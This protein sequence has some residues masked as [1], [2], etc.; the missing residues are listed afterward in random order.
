M[1]NGEAP[2]ST[3]NPGAFSIAKRHEVLSLT[4]VVSQMGVKSGHKW[5]FLPAPIVFISLQY[6][7]IGDSVSLE[8]TEGQTDCRLLFSFSMQKEKKKEPQKL[9]ASVGIA[10]ALIF[11]LWPKHISGQLRSTVRPA[12]RWGLLF[13]TEY[14]KERY[15]VK[16]SF[17]NSV[18][19]CGIAAEDHWF[20]SDLFKMSRLSFTVQTCRVHVELHALISVQATNWTFYVCIK[21]TTLK[22]VFNNRNRVF[23]LPMGWRLK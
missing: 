1:A 8:N 10:F 16:G 17:A 4:W 20:L 3:A 19:Y 12:K 15:I 5:E 6:L 2:G 21:Y 9:Q 22:A 14:C 11:F 7:R 23:F 18:R 13:Q